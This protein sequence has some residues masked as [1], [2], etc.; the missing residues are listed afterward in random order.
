MKKIKVLALLATLFV[1]IF[2]NLFTTVVSAA[3]DEKVS[4]TLH[5]VK[6]HTDK[7]TNT[8]DILDGE[9]NFLP[10][11]TFDAYDV[12]E[13]YYAAY[14]ASVETKSASEAI[15]D[16]VTAV[17]GKAG[18]APSGKTAVDTQTTAADGSAAFS[19][20][21]KSGPTTDRRDA[22]YLF[23]EQASDGVDTIAENLVVSLPIYKQGT[24]DTVLTDIHLYPKKILL[25]IFRLTKKLQVKRMVRN[26]LISQ[27]VKLS[28][29]N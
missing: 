3:D 7:I 14:D 24:N 8:G 21:A 25:K 17:Q 13:K 12:T 20:S 29:I 15:K 27:L 4:I 18:D 16:A 26:K 11:I 5:K 9:Y 28:T 2:S 6:D 1:G 10:G 23:V 19:L 22:V